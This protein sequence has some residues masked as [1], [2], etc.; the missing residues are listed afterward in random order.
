[1]V[2]HIRN[3]QTVRME[4]LDHHIYVMIMSD[5]S[6]SHD[7]KHL[8]IVDWFIVLLRLDL[9]RW[10]FIWNLWWNCEYVRFCDCFLDSRILISKID[11]FY[12]ELVELSMN[13]ENIVNKVD[14][15][16]KLV[17]NWTQGRWIPIDFVK[18]RNYSENYGYKIGGMG[19]IDSDKTNQAHYVG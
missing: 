13:L 15:E 12:F 17:K 11:G 3:G 10:S 5:L 4:S 6:L 7:F 2:S 1:M 19:Y 9:K 8:F 16:D 18:S 14:K